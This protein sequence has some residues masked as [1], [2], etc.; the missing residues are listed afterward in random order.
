[1]KHPVFKVGDIIILKDNIYNEFNPD[2][3]NTPLVIKEIHYDHMMVYNK[4]L[5]Y[6]GVIKD[7]EYRDVVLLK[8]AMKNIPKKEI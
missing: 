6:D 1:M 2:W 7:D 5:S 3:I 4:L 8:K